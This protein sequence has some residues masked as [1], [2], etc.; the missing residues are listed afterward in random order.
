[1]A[2][3]PPAR[4]RL[5]SDIDFMV[6]RDRID[7]VE[8]ILVKAD[9]APAVKDAY[10]QRYYRRWTHQIPPLKHF[11][12]TTVLDVRRSEEHTTDLQSL[13]RISYAISSLKKTTQKPDP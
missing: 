4:G 5:F 7:E 2:G 9:W 1:M 13:M 11:Q 10:D 12:R 6:P 8:R 3:L